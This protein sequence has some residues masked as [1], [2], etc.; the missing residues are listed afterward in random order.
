M[1]ASA[2]VTFGAL[3]GASGSARRSPSCPHRGAGDAH[4]ARRAP[5]PGRRHRA[6]ARRAPGHAPAADRVAGAGRRDRHGLPVL[7][8]ALTLADDLKATLGAVETLRATRH[9]A[10]RCRSSTPRWRSPRRSLDFIAPMQTRCNYLGLWTRNANSSISEGDANGNW[11]RTLVI[12]NTAEFTS[13]AEPAPELHA[14]PYP[15][16]AAPGQDG[17]CEAGNEGYEPGQ[18]IGNPPGNQGRAPSRPTPTPG[19]AS[20]E[21]PRPPPPRSHARLGRRPGRRRAG[22][23]RHLPRVRRPD[24]VAERLRAQGGRR[25]RARAAVALAGADRGR[26]GRAAS[27]RSSAGPATP[28]SS[29][30]RSRSPGLPIHEDATLKVRPRIFLE[31]NFFVDLRPGTPQSPTVSSGHTLPISQ[32]AVPVQLDEILSSLQKDTRKQL[33]RFVHGLSVTMDDGGGQDAQ[34]DAGGVGPGVH[35][36]GDRHRGRARRARRRPVA[37]SSPGRRRPRRA[38][39]PRPA[40]GHADRRPGAHGH[41][42]GQP[43][44]AARAVA[45]RARRALH[46]APAALRAVDDALPETR[47]LAIEARPALREAPTTLRLADPVLAQARA[48]VAP[49][50]LPAL[51]GQL[52]PAL[53]D[54]APLE[55][56]LTPLLGQVT[57]IMDCLRNNAMPTLK[58]PV[59]DGALTTGDPPYRELLHGLTGLVE[60]VAELRRQRARRSATTRLRRPDGHVRARAVGRRGA[61]RDD[62]RADP[63]LAAAQAPEQPPFRPDVPCHTQEP[64]NLAAATG[65]APRQRQVDLKAAP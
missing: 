26:R 45:A 36:R 49:G 2:D 44:R 20:R 22:R 9:H 55:P 13:A 58:T 15:N 53:D 38:R 63:R 39:E 47:A 52:D 6:D 29:R 14:N 57:P 54:L 1:I 11:F 19:G 59:E 4:A 3:A 31:G 61:G 33:T 62:L 17:E 60:R 34:G 50:E 28:R 48:L 42:A 18:R 12:A 46:E 24:A 64:P 41:G 40:A 5:V 25:V 51:I 35:A 7:R 16:T 8:R 27:R 21:A 56:R 30:W 23:D 10:R 65:P 43:P 32:T 37:A